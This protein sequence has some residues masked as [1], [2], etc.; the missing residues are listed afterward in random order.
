LESGRCLQSRSAARSG[1][2]SKGGFR[3]LGAG[4]GEKA[5]VVGRG[6]VDRGRGFDKGAIKLT[7]GVSGLQEWPSGLL[8][9]ISYEIL[10]CCHGRGRGFEPRRPRHNPKKLQGYGFLEWQSQTSTVRNGTEKFC[11]VFSLP[12]IG[13]SASCSHPAY[14]RRQFAYRGP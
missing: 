3:N 7:N 12:S 8:I 11:T 10:P 9:S 4:V 5:K 13:L 6:L 14:Q 2:T 1:H